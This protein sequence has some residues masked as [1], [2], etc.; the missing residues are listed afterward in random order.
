[1]LVLGTCSV[2]V[3][4]SFRALGPAQEQAAA[5]HQR[6]EAGQ[7]AAIYAGASPEFQ[8]DT[9]REALQ[10]YL[11]G[12]RDRMGKCTPPP[13]KPDSYFANSSSSG[14]TIRLSYSL[15]C[16]NGH[17][18]EVITFL[19]EDGMPKLFQYQASSRFLK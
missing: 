11:Q 8:R 19:S 4:K 3:I 14:T 9:T 10:R 12:I 2:F 15:Q 5:F 16:S 6:F 18:D 17:L 1:M 13:G 7:Y